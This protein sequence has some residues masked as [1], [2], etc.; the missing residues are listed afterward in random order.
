[1][2]IFNPNSGIGHNGNFNPPNSGGSSG[3]NTKLTTS[4]SLL[5]SSGGLTGLSGLL[6]TP[7][8]T[9]QGQCLVAIHDPT[10]FNCE[11]D[12]EYDYPQEI[13]PIQYQDSCD[14]TWNRIKLKYR[15][16]GEVSFTLQIDY[17]NKT[18]DCFT[19]KKISLKISNPYPVRNTFPDNKIHT[20]YIPLVISGER[21]QIKVIRKA[22]KGPLSITKLLFC[23]CA[24]ETPQM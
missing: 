18:T 2:Q 12:C 1:M 19:T 21:P 14:A 22:N 3:G 17:Y 20:R 7:Y 24:D 10:D 4:P 15:E 16:L 9:P 6:M 23:G 5:T 8:F 13:P 11:E